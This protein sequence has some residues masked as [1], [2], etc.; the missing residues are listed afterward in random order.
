M[1]TKSVITSFLVLLVVMLFAGGAI[2]ADV[3]GKWIA[4][5]SSPSGSTGERIFTFKVSGNELTGTVMNF[6][7]AMA[8]FEPEGQPKMTGKLTI[9]SG[10]PQEISD[11]K[12]SGDNIS[13]TT[14]TRRGE[15]EIKTVYSGQISGAEIKFTAETVLPEGFSFPGPPGGPRPEEL[16]AKRME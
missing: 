9:Q 4:E 3:S 1:R 2:A 5:T 16:V 6:E 15:M 14:V 10:S 8:T 12:M 13:F 11:G 7:T